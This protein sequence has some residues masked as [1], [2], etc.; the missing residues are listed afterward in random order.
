MRIEG[1]TGTEDQIK[2]GKG[3]S[4]ALWTVQGLLA[5]LFVL[6]GVMKFV[7]PMTQTP[8]QSWMTGPFLLF[9]G[10]CEVLGGIGLVLP[11]LL[12]IL[13]VLTPVAACGLVVIMIGAAVVVMPMGFFAVVPLFFAALAA[14]VAYGRFRVRPIPPRHRS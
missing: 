12:R 1:M 14:F 11:A 3:L 10:A 6:S 7:M 4:I 2:S 8:K 5:A 13:P 9:I